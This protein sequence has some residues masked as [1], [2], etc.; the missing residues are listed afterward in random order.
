MNIRDGW[1]A[2]VLS[3]ILFLEDMLFFLYKRQ[4]LGLGP[5]AREP[6]SAAKLLGLIQISSVGSD[7][8]FAD[9]LTESRY[10]KC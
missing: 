5:V 4:T 6:F 3:R 2:R 10:C 7:K 9:D 8:S 1:D